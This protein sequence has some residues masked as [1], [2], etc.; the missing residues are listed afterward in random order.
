MID[1]DSVTGSVKSVCHLYKLRVISFK[2]FC[3]LSH[4]FTV[5]TY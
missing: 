2:I 1:H 4:T 5:R 3:A